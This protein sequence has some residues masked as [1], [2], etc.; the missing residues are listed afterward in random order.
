M[1]ENVSSTLPADKCADFSLNS[2]GYGA[3]DESTG[4][5]IRQFPRKHPHSDPPGIFDGLDSSNSTIVYNAVAI[6]I[7]KL[8]YQARGQDAQLFL[9]KIAQ[10]VHLLL[11]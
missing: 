11:G 10:A 7:E 9:G 1:I 3:C 5:Y 2:V 6:G 4:I 8:I